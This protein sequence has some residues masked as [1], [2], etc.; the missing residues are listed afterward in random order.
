MPASLTYPQYVTVSQIVG[1]AKPESLSTPIIPIGRSTWWK[2]VKDG[3]APKPI[4]LGSRTAVW[5]LTD[6]IA[7]VESQSGFGQE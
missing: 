3:R 5:R 4:K 2:A 1:S 7:F 6:V